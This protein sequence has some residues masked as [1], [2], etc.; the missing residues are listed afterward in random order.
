[1]F[2]WKTTESTEK[3]GEGERSE[4]ERKVEEIIWS[5]E[6]MANGKRGMGRLQ[7]GLYSRRYT[8]LYSVV[9]LEMHSSENTIWQQLAETTHPPAGVI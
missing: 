6:R 9:R 1:M 2:A 4:E 3:K 8:A 7:E 5:T